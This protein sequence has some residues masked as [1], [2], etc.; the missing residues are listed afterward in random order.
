MYSIAALCFCLAIAVFDIKTFRIPDSLLLAFVTIMIILREN[1]PYIS[2]IERFSAA[3]AA[4]L[5]F[6][7]VCYY[8][9]GM[10][11]GDVKYAASL[12][13][14]LGSDR[15]LIAFFYTAF[16]SIVIYLIGI[17]LFHWP[18]TVKIQFAPFLSAGVIFVLLND[19]IARFIV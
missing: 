4:L 14:I 13:Y 5:I 10:G 19:N 9:K 7:A 8:S 11:L 16:L 12:G 18:K 6:G 2:V 3:L 1:G 15:L 17:L